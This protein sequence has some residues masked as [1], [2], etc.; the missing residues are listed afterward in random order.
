MF[1]LGAFAIIFDE[2]GSVLLC[3]RRDFDAWNLPGGGIENGELPTEAVIREVKE[4]TGLEVDVE[5]LV[6]VYGKTDKDQLVFSFICCPIG[7]ILSATDESSECQY[8]S[9]EEIPI[10]TIS[11]HVERIHDALKSTTQPI[12]RRQG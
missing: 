5:R 8:F 7:G 11:I 9:I 3:H 6:G 10:N 12:F 1:K 2:H 4:E